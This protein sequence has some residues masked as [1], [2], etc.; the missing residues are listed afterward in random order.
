MG[1]S[2]TA[3]DAGWRARSAAAQDAAL[4][5]G[6]VVVTCSAPLGAGG[7]GRH[8]QEILDALARSGAQAQSVSDSTRKA[9][10]RTHWSTFFRAGPLLRRS[11]AGRAWISSVRFDE[12]AAAHL[13]A[14]EHLIAFNGT[15]R[16]QFRAA[17]SRGYRTLTLVSANSHIEQMRERHERAYRDYPVERPWSSWLVRRNR[18]EYAA[19]QRILVSSRYI[20]ESFVERGFPP[21]RLASFPLTPD[22][23]FAP[24]PAPAAPQASTFDVVYVGSLVVHKGVPLLLDA[25][26]RLAYADMRLVLV[27]GWKTL[28][29]RRLVEG[30]HARDPRIVIA[31]GDPLAYL[32]GARVCAHPAYEDGFGYAP[33][34]A[35]AAGV[36]VIVSEDTGMK[37]LIGGEQDG[38]I[39]PTGDRD[40]LVEALAAA[41][42]GEV[43]GG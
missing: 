26:S 18:S 10:P 14:A 27:G 36:P 29:M 4:P 3:L 32:R 5:S 42:R 17:R 28:S 37:E 33:A 13:P 12:Y 15:A 25:F 38:L 21:E 23:R 43:L 19:A 40:A 1:T 24:D 20:W 7:L 6:S 39:V 8:L 34:E 16:A 31:P 41:Y 35:L 11:P 30:A 22:A 2:P 9:D